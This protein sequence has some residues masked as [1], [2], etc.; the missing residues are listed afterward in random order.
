MA[1]LLITFLFFGLMTST[2]TAAQAD[3]LIADFQTAQIDDA[4]LELEED[5]KTG[6]LSFRITNQALSNL[7]ILGVGGPNNGESA[8]L[9]RIDD[10][11]Y[12][13][14]DSISLGR[15]ETLNLTTSHIFIKM[16]GFTEPISIHEKIKLVLRLSRG[17]IPFEAHVKSPK[18]Y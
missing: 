11:N 7:T 9:V 6:V 13:E 16:S 17:E 10:T 12:V 3:N 15:E 2:I 14:L 8:I 4:H 1:K 18:I 5:E